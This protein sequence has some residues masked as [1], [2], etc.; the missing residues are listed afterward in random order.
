MSGYTTQK[1]FT[2][3]ELMIAI[4]LG[5]LITAAAMQLFITGQTSI[6][7][8]RGMADIQ[9]SGNFGLNY[10]TFDIRR[11]NFGATQDI[12]NDRLVSGGIVLT[13][14]KVPSRPA[15]DTTYTDAN[16]PVN[17]PAN[18]PATE[19]IPLSSSSAGSSN[20]QLKSGTTDFSDQGSDQLVIQFFAE[21]AGTDCEGNGYTANRYVIE[22]FF[23]RA[24]SNAASNEPNS[25]LALACEAGSYTAASTA[26]YKNST[27]SPPKFGTTSGQIIMRRVD[28]LHFLLGVSNDN[29]T[30]DLRYISINQYL[31]LNA[32]PRPR[33]NSIQIGML[34][35]ASDNIGSNSLVANDQEF[36]ILEQ[37]VK[38]KTP[39]G[40]PPKYLRQVVSQTVAIRNGLN[41]TDIATGI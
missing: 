19:D 1:G 13:S 30:G 8:Q 23:L 25:A 5:L 2:L 31:S 12:V 28:H 4:I 17:T 37:T 18:I 9:D 27:G 6:N 20:V 3:I 7:M 16:I 22:R 36:T 14:R 34:V 38:V 21:Q 41:T 29:N 32:N 15:V 24:D 35:R 39:T 11:T 10:L 26:I 40:T 33:I